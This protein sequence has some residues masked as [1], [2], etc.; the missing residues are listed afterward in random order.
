M[1]TLL[2]DLFKFRRLN[3][4][5]LKN[6]QSR[7]FYSYVLKSEQKLDPPKAKMQ[8]IIFDLKTSAAKMTVS[9]VFKCFRLL[10]VG[11]LL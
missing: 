3:V 10:H 5:L 9:I 4:V 1:L 11:H 2:V 8:V 7:T 6:V